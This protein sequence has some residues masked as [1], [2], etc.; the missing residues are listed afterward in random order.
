MYN[1]SEYLMSYALV[2][3]FVVLGMLVVCIPRPRKAKYLTKEQLAKEKIRKANEK[4]KAR[5][6]KDAAK[7][8][9]KAKKK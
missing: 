6:Q 3:A 4:A 2:A 8:K 1:Q 9:K 5:A 7:R